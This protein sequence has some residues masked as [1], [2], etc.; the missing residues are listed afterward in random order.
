M[1]CIGGATG[2][3]NWSSYPKIRDQGNEGTREEGYKRTKEQGK[4]GARGDDLRAPVLLYILLTQFS[5][6]V[7][8]SRRFVC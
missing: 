2:R 4:P 8:F 7:G 6:A 3:W 5:F 1:C